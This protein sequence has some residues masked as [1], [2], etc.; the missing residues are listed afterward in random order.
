[1]FRRRRSGILGEALRRSQDPELADLQ[2]MISERQERVAELELEYFEARADLARFQTEVNRRLTPLQT[3]LRELQDQVVR[4]RRQAA[5][6]AQWGERAGTD[7]VPVDVLEQFERTWRKQPSQPSQAPPAKVD[8]RTKTLIKTEY[9]RLA[10]RFHPD[11]TSDP[12]EKK[13]R[14]GVMAQVNQAYADGDL[15]K[16]R[17]LAGKER[18]PAKEVTKSR[19]E[20][21]AEMRRE[22][23]RLDK[24]I[25]Q[26][27]A[28]LSRLT[29]S[30]EVKLMLD[31]SIAEREGRDLIGEMASDLRR[32]IAELEIEL[33]ELDDS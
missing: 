2:E 29:R 5:H 3:R 21:L 15:A 33:V 31:A 20:V 1:M 17:E 28:E 25:R 22:V 7:E 4:A 30:A 13:W 18:R 11:L 8:D 19:E 26:L 14:E 6:R 27:E 24:L 9:R 10:K 12:D 16:L 32:T 23:G